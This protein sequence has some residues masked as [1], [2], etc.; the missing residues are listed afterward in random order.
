MVG[1]RG[2]MA[3]VEQRDQPVLRACLLDVVAK[4]PE[5]QHAVREARDR[6]GEAEQRALVLRPGAVAGAV[7]HSPSFAKNFRTFVIFNGEAAAL[8]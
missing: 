6:V 7:R 2:H 8:G 4:V 5:R 3:A 1:W